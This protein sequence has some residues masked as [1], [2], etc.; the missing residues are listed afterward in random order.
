MTCIQPTCVA[1]GRYPTCQSYPSCLSTRQLLDC[2]LAAELLPELQSAYRAFHSTETAVVKV[3]A[4]VLPQCLHWIPAMWMRSN[5]LQ[6]N[7]AKTEVLWCASSRRQHQLPQVALRVDTDYVTPTTSVRDLGIYVD[8]DVS[9][10]ADER[11]Q[12]RVR[13]LAV[14]RQL[15]SIRR[16]TSQAVLLPQSSFAFWRQDPR[17]WISAILH[18]GDRQTDRLKN[19]QMDSTD[20]LSRS[21]CRERRLNNNEC[22][23]DDTKAAACQSLNCIKNKKNK[24]WRKRFSIW[25]IRILTP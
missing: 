22:I 19:E 2:L 11:V 6:L 3:L 15:R 5:R 13:L 24:N 17:W 20:A 9:M 23:G 10:H 16:S 21:R 12:D 4:D 14:L 25:R 8:S 1:I 7:T 18:F